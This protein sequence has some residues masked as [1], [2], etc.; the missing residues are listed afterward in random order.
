VFEA[1]YVL[2]A[3]LQRGKAGCAIVTLRLH[4][5]VESVD[6]SEGNAGIVVERG[7]DL[8]VIVGRARLDDV[9]AERA[10]H[11]DFAD[12]AVEGSYVGIEVVVF[13]RACPDTD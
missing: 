13:A 6:E 4:F 5:A 9:F 11:G 10:Q 1:L 12:V 7:A 8:F 3:V 2:Q